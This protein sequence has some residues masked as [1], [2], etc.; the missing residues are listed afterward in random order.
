MVELTF[1]NKE[2]REKLQEF[3]DKG[4]SDTISKG[5]TEACIIVESEAKQR[6]PVDDGQ[7]R[8]SITHEVIVNGNECEAVV[9]TNVEYAPYVELGTGIYNPTGRQIPWVYQDAKGNFHRTKGM[10]AQ[11]Y[12][13]PAADD[14]KQEILQVFEGLV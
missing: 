10:K 12:L 11:P 1:D 9:G 4:L 2:V 3:I 6:C 14:K 8:Q 7:L 5:L 13:Q